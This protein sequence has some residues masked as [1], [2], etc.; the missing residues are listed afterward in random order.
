MDSQDKGTLQTHE[1]AQFKDINSSNSLDEKKQEETTNTD[2]DTQETYN[3]NSKAFPEGMQLNSFHND[4]RYNYH[5]YNLYLTPITEEIDHEKTIVGL[6]EQNKKLTDQ[7]RFLNKKLTDILDKQQKKVQAK[8]ELE[9]KSKDIT[10]VQKELENAYKKIEYLQ[11][12]NKFLQQK[13]E[14]LSPSMIQNLEVQLKEREQLIQKQQDEIKAFENIKRMLEKNNSLESKQI[15]VITKIDD[16]EKKIVCQNSEIKKLKSLLDN[17]QK[18]MLKKQ[19]YQVDLEQKF[20]E[21]C[22]YL[23]IS[24]STKQNLK[25]ELQ[26]IHISKKVESNPQNVLTEINKNSQDNSQNIQSPHK[27]VN[28]KQYEIQ[29]KELNA[30]VKLK[31]KEISQLKLQIQELK[32]LP[33]QENQPIIQHKRVNKSIS[34]I[35]SQGLLNLQPISNIE[36]TQDNSLTEKRD[37]KQNIISK[38]ISFQHQKE[39]QDPNIIRLSSAKVNSNQSQAQLL[40]LK[41]EKQRIKKEIMGKQ[42][43]CTRSITDRNILKEQLHSKIIKVIVWTN[44]RTINGVQFFYK[45]NENIV[46]GQKM[47]VDNKNEYNQVVFDFNNK[48]DSNNS[49]SNKQLQVDYLKQVECMMSSQGYIDKLKFI[50]ATGKVYEAGAQSN[51]GKIVQKFNLDQCEYPVCSFGGLITFVGEKEQEVGSILSFL[52]FEV[53]VDRQVLQR[54]NSQYIPKGFSTFYF[55][56]EQFKQLLNVQK[57]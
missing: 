47:V 11:K 53:M 36:K 9:Q 46:E 19:E 20:R 29:I 25:E 30:A 51:Q 54:S 3:D 41:E 31:D 56:K 34:V 6:K 38:D 16:Q 28:Y 2:Q 33:R 39:N 12:Q 26:K 50:S 27:K 37:K 35:K 49:N 13:L 44:K 43:G 4:Y 23:G 1:Q 18:Q 42:H 57:Q 52:G 8:Q 7:L 24:S 5:P 40:P 32:H 45:V 14:K 17:Q 21:I 10:I 22:E 48:T 15:D 55:D